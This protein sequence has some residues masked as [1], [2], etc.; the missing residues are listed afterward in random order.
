MRKIRLIR[1]S[2]LLFILG[3]LLQTCPA[4]CATHKLKMKKF[5]GGF[6]SINKPGGWKIIT[7][8]TCGSFAFLIR[9]PSESLRQIFYFGEVGPVYL[10]V[11]QK[12]IDQQYMSMGGYP[13]GWIDMPVVNPLTPGEFL[14]NFHIIAKSQVAQ[15]FMPG[16]PRLENIKVISKKSEP[17]PIPGG[18]TELLR[19]L[20]TK[21]GK[22]GEGLFLITVAPMLPFTGNPG[23]GIGYGFLV[24]GIT[25]PKKEFKDLEKSLA[26]SIK[27]FWV[28]QNYVNNCLRQQASTYAG[29][30]KAGKTLNETSDIIMKGWEARNKTEDIL[31]EKWSD[32]ILGKERLYNPL[33]GKVY[34]FENGFYDKYNHNRGEYDMNKLELLPKDNYNLWMK[35]PLDGHKNIR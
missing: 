26:N 8:G 9:D 16:C 18:S 12:Q 35:V 33:S 4:A 27:S 21:N 20:F 7:A 28:S 17:C 14:S 2:A 25:A 31:S 29:I 6:F 34:E 3:I 15:Q 32:A 22:L 30:L 10:N 24:T 1:I 11:Q 19:A 23:G 5:E 13:V